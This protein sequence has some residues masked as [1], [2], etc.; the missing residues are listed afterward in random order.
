MLRRSSDLC[1]KIHSAD[2]REMVRGQEWTIWEAI[3]IIQEKDDC[4]L[5]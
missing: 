3:A 4:G 5:N 1:N 2:I